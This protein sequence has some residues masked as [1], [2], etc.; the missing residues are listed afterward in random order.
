VG[1]LEGGRWADCLNNRTLCSLMPSWNG[2]QFRRFRLCSGLDSK[3]GI[4]D[5]ELVPG[6]ALG[7]TDDKHVVSEDSVYPLNNQGR[8]ADFSSSR[9]QGVWLPR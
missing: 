1:S 2:C 9:T 4:L 6:V 7:R 3:P 5:L 8:D